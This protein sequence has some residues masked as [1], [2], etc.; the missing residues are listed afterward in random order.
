MGSRRLL[1]TG[2]VFQYPSPGG[3]P[4]THP[5]LDYAFGNNIISDST[6][7]FEETTV[8]K[9]I[10]HNLYHPP[11]T[12]TP[13]ILGSKETIQISLSD[14][15]VREAMAPPYIKK[16]EHAFDSDDDT[17]SQGGT[18]DELDEVPKRKTREL[19][20]Y[21]SYVRGWDTAFAFREFYQNCWASLR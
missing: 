18:D 7:H 5:K 19:N 6:E 1:L 9:E 20:I 17:V 14:N 11:S 3:N 8:V 10:Q 15:E 2:P 16:E 21:K 12:L 4:E 13:T